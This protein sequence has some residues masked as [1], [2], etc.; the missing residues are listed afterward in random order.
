[1]LPRFR[2]AAVLAA[3]CTLLA[4]SAATAAIPQFTRVALMGDSITAN[5]GTEFHYFRNALWSTLSALLNQRVQLVYN[6]DLPYFATPGRDS[7]YIQSVHLPQVLASDAEACILLAGTNDYGNGR[8]P[9]EVA[10]TLGQICHSLE[11]GGITPIL[12]DVLPVPPGQAAKSAW[13]ATLRKDVTA[14][15]KADPKILYINWFRVLDPAG[16]GKSAQTWFLDETHPDANGMSR[17]AAYAAAIIQPH[18]RPSDPFAGVVWITPNPTLG[19]ASKK[20]TAPDGW[21][22]DTTA[23]TRLIP[24]GPTLGN[25]WQLTVKGND[26]TTTGI[27]CGYGTSGVDWSPGDTIELVAEFQTTG[28]VSANWNLSPMMVVHPSNTPRTDWDLADSGAN[29]L[30]RPPSGILCTPP[31]VIPEGTTS[32]DVY[33]EVTGTGTF[34]LGRTGIRRR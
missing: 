5:T 4:C 31:L 2:A 23:T 19:A 32:F 15:C 12:C 18:L 30:K 34:K 10:L 28:N 11:A 27:Y 17:L 7:L 21:S 8:T 6:G 25:W 20:A 3:A 1:M 26:S 9:A 24:R 16:D 29:N 33:L 22:A 13:L 14:L